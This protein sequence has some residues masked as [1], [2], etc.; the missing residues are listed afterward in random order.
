MLLGAVGAINPIA[1]ANISTV[2]QT[3]TPDYLLGRV[4]A[5][6]SVGAMTALTAGSVAGG[7]LGDSFGLRPTLLLGGLLPLIGLGWVLLSPVR[8]LR[9]LDAS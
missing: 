7:L 4:T 8:R 2:R 6:T 3:V 1:G 5:V 9:R